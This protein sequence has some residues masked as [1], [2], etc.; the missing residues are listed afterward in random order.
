MRF[1]FRRRPKEPVSLPEWLIVGLGN[2]GP[3]YRGTRHNVG[4]AV[5]EELARRHHARLGSSRHRSRVGSASIAGSQVLL[6]MPLTYMNLC[7]QSVGP[8][9]HSLDLAPER[10]L[11]IS[12][13]LDLPL[14]KVRL[15]PKGGAG[16][17]N[18]HKSLIAALH[19]QNY[20]R[21]R[22]GIGRGESEAVDHVLSTFDRDERT[23]IEAAI[24]QAADLCEGIVT[25][26]LETTLSVAN[27]PGET[28]GEDQA[29]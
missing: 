22:I 17:H 24:A 4:F 27:P 18:G 5:I 12:D 8:L 25:N 15:R 11:A 2:P 6:A 28:K 3:E 23:V 19:S 26:G 9:A 10:V 14:G 20:P 29:E 21:I 7:G 16:G 1:G 13:E